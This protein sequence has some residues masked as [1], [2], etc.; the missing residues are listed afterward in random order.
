MMAALWTAHL[1]ISWL[2]LTF[3]TFPLLPLLLPFFNC[4]FP[5]YRAHFL[6]D[7]HSNPLRTQGT[8][9]KQQPGSLILLPFFPTTN[10]DAPATHRVRDEARHGLASQRCPSESFKQDSHMAP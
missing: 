2:V 9:R 3:S 5:T 8:L 1:L 4:S 10:D 7:S 6:T